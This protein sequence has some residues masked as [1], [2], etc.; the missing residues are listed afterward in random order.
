MRFG[1]TSTQRRQSAHVQTAGSAPRR[2]CRYPGCSIRGSAKSW[3]MEI[4]V[5]STRRCGLVAARA[6]P[7]K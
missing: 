4:W 1:K 6:W 3:L 5:V 7:E 2:A